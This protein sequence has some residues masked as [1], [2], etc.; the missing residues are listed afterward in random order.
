MYYDMSHRL[1]RSMLLEECI[2]I[3]NYKREF[4]ELNQYIY[5]DLYYINILLLLKSSQ[6]TSYVIIQHI[7]VGEFQ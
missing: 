5:I 4:Y 7:F 2:I 3:N 1:L 6:E